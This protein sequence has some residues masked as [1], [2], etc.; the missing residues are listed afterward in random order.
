[1]PEI[2]VFLLSLATTIRGADWLGKSAVS[3]GKNIG[4]PH[5]VIGATFISVAT[6]LPEI[7]FATFSSLVNKEPQLALGAVIGSA[8]INSGLLLGFYFFFFK[9]RPLLGYFSRA[10]NIFFVISILLLVISVNI[11]FGNFVSFLLIAL[12]GLFIFLEF[13]IGSKSQNLAEKLESRFEGF[14]SIFNFAKNK[15][16]VFEFIFGIIF[17]IIG[18]SLMVTSSLSIANSFRLDELYLS[19]TVVALGTSLPE[20][21]ILLNCLKNGKEGVSI[22]NLVGSS[23]INLTIG[24]GIATFLTKTI[25]IFPI[26]LI[27]FIPL[28]IIGVLMILSF[29][30]KFS[31]RLIGSL[32]VST[33]IIFFLI[34]SFYEFI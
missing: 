8:L 10:V 26:N 32:L 21:I 20:L 23:V 1:M 25:I 11:S 27:I 28:I 15:S 22:G 33:I 16:I 5:F 3:W 30:G 31:L 17:L 13:I 2:I 14:I 12:G 7:T 24:V 29:W 6:T 19:V 18:S 34:F 9:K 4:L